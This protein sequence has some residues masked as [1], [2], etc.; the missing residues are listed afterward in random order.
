MIE[1]HYRWKE[2]EREMDVTERTE[3]YW[4]PFVMTH[5]SAN[6]TLFTLDDKVDGGFF[7]SRST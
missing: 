6:A 5:S 4:D 2:G 1:H 3:G 7:P